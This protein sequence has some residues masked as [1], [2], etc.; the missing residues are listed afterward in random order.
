MRTNSIS[1]ILLAALSAPC[2]EASA[3]TEEKTLFFISNTHLDTQWNWEVNT[4][5]NSYIKNTLTQNMALMDKYPLFRLNYEGAIRYMWM[6]EYYPTEYEA[7][8][9]YVASGQWHVSGMSMDATDVMVSSAESILHSMLYANQFYKQE[10]GVRGGYDIMLPDCFG[11]SYALPSLARHAGVKGFHTAKLAW[12]SAAYGSLPPFGIWQGVDGSQIYAIYKPG[13]YDS[14]EEFNKD[15]TEDESYAK[16]IQDNYDKYGVP[17]VVRYV[18]P[19]SDRGGGLKDDA[20]SS[21]ENT[22]YWLNLMAGKQDGKFGVKLASPDEI[23]DFLD[24]Y[25]N[26]KYHVWD[27]ELPMRTHGVGSYTSWG[28]LKRWNR[29][30]EL[31]AD[32]AEKASS[33]AYWLGAA[34]YPSQAIREAWIRTIWQQH[35]DGITGTSTLKANDYSTNEYYLAN[36]TF[37]QQLSNAVAAIA[38]LLDTQVQGTPIIVYNPLSHN[39]QDIVEGS[40]PCDSEPYS[41]R[42]VGPDG[43]EVLS[44]IT[45][46]D[47]GEGKV[48]FIFAADVPSLGCAVYDVRLGESSG[49]ESPLTVD[50]DER[51]IS[52]GS[53]TVTIN[54]NGDISKVYDEEGKRSLI[55]G[56]VRQM[57]IYDHEDTWPAWEISYTDVCRTPSAYVSGNADIRLVERG[58][59][60]TSFR[61]ER[62]K[63]GST[64]VQYVRMNALSDRIDC[65]NE[66][67]WQT[68]ERMLKVQFPFSF[69]NQK[70]T[71]DISLGTVS[72]G[73]RSS[74]EYE[75]VGHQW[76]DHSNTTGAYGVS[77]LNDCKYGWDKPA[78][79]SLRLTLLHTPSC[80]SY[81]HQAN[82]DIGPNMFTYS[83]L[84]HRSQWIADTQMEASRLNQPL[85]AFATSKHSGSLGRK[86]DFAKPNTNGISIKALKKA[87]DTDEL[88]VRVYEWTGNDQQDVRI[89]F[90][91]DIA[92]AREVNALE[93]EQGNATFQGNE[94][95]FDIGHYQPKTFAVRLKP[96]NADTSTANSLGTPATFTPNIDL[97]SYDRKR[98]NA[99]ATCTYAY[100]A[101][102]IDD[103]I[104]VDG[105]RFVMADRTDGKYNAIRTAGN[106][107]TLDRQPGEDCL[108]LLLASSSEQGSDVTVTHGDSTTVLK[109]PYYSGRVGSPLTCTTLE[110]SYRKDAN[111]ALAMSH[112][113][114]ISGKSNEAMTMMYMYKYSIPLDD[115]V[116]EVTLSAANRKAYLFAATTASGGGNRVTAF[117]PLT[118]EIEYSELAGSAD[119]DR[120]KPSAVTCSHQNGTAEAGKYAN[121]Q[122]ASTKWCVTESQSKTPYL[123][124]TFSKPV[125]IDK[126]MV[127]GAARESGGYTPSAFKLQYLGTDGTW[128]DADQVDDNQLNK[129]IRQVSP[130]TTSKVRL[131]MIQGEQNGYVTRINEF[132]VYGMTE[133]D[134]ETDVLLPSPANEAEEATPTYDLSGRKVNPDGLHKGIYIRNGEKFIGGSR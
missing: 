63:E 97:M 95:C 49:L 134:Y 81:Q 54:A 122:D 34:D 133:E 55:N 75:V 123:Q 76:A 85:L 10:F 11:F 17:A 68:H 69:S 104:L 16:Q 28:L 109:V 15:L 131:Q 108:H 112:A 61:I 7:L 105:V 90:P 19:R 96:S 99:T 110:A 29:K 119:D 22:P 23:F 59:L 38:P 53:Y 26:G 120:L 82:M 117:T 20:S 41:L 71:Y 62:S 51:R 74:D 113:H 114:S 21:G 8:K 18:G 72:R 57:M 129:V 66:V 50:E 60:R 46:Y 27:G 3:E 52:N 87:E 101:E 9:K 130:F 35:H 127:L 77:I 6:K 116:T 2:L 118:T 67:D 36:K 94:L 65:V 121:D 5:I 37:A 115:D 14:H 43:R 84:P 106:K 12:G 44:Q 102:L 70:D 1:A 64:F 89:A 124:Y 48:S 40:M 24:K 42:V 79:N 45:G 83:I 4:T 91:A 98:G 126:W 92:S 58:P 107:V 125:R 73:V 32:A 56:A 25:K 30:N 93:E 111:V 39:R 128:I 33:L 78:N 86:M 31:L 13:A 88:I 103:S 80:G 132:A 47:A 100:P